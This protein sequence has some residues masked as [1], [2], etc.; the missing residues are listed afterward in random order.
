[1]S[2]IADKAKSAAKAKFEDYINGNG[3]GL[4][5]KVKEEWAKAK[6]EF[7]AH[8]SMH[9]VFSFGWLANEHAG[10]NEQCV[11]DVLATMD[12]FKDE[13]DHV[14]V[15]KFFADNPEECKFEVSII[16]GNLRDNTYMEMVVE[17]K[18]KKRRTDEEAVKSNEAPVK[19][20]EDAEP[21]PGTLGIKAPVLPPPLRREESDP[22][23][24]FNA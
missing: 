18:A 1:M 2:M 11:K 22:A 9:G 24:L 23:P 21:H 3:D 14:H 12:D 15:H 10:L 19:E 5:D 20:E 17:H 6:P 7:L 16:Y 13:M 8:E 4:A